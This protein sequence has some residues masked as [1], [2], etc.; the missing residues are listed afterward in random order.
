ME[1]F[2]PFCSA[3]LKSNYNKHTWTSKLFKWFETGRLS[4]FLSDEGGFKAPMDEFI[5]DIC[6][7]EF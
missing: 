1:H 5:V 7:S 6:L 4:K 3:L 2:Q